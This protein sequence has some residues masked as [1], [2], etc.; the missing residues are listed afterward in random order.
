MKIEIEVPDE[1]AADLLKKLAE[2]MMHPGSAS[3]GG[4]SPSSIFDPAKTLPSPILA[5]DNK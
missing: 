4:L 2:R 3:T 5:K 1:A